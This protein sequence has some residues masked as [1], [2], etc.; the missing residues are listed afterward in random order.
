MNY[1]NVLKYISIVF[2]NVMSK[3]YFCETILSTCS[4]AHLNRHILKT[5]YNQHII[6]TIQH[7]LRGFPLRHPLRAVHLFMSW[8]ISSLPKLIWTSKL[9]K[10]KMINVWFLNFCQHSRREKM[11]L[12]DT[13]VQSNYW[14]YCLNSS[15]SLKCYGWPLTIRVGCSYSNM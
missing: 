11:L 10:D 15:P 12:V 1:K 3:I 2:Y 4:Y 13:N 7:C 14:T 8:F 6:P 9:N 5:K